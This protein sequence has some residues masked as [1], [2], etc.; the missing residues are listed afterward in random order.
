MEGSMLRLSAGIQH[1]LQAVEFDRIQRWYWAQNECVV[2]EHFLPDEVLA[3]YL[4][5]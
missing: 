4:L 5:P 2:L 1:A 3:Q